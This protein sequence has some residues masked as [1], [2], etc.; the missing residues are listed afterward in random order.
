MGETPYALITFH[1]AEDTSGYKRF[2]FGVLLPAVIEQA[3][4]YRAVMDIELRNIFGFGQD[5]AD[6]NSAQWKQFI[7][8]IINFFEIE[9]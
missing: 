5:I 2:Y 8:S 9:L 4:E 7:D 6:Y 1:S 3:G